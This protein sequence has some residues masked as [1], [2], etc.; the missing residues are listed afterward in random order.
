MLKKF[1]LTSTITRIYCEN[2]V[3][4]FT[5]FWLL[6]F[7][8]HFTLFSRR[9]Y[10]LNLLLYDYFFFFCF[11]FFSFNWFLFLITCLT[12]YFLGFDFLRNFILIF[13][14]WIFFIVFSFFFIFLI[15]FF[16]IIIRAWFLLIVTTL[17]ILILFYSF[18]FFFFLL[19]FNVIFKIEHIIVIL[20]LHFILLKFSFGIFS[21][22]MIFHQSLIAS[23]CQNVESLIISKHIL[24]CLI[25]IKHFVFIPS[26]KKIS[27][28]WLFLSCCLIWLFCVVSR[29]L[30]FVIWRM[31][32]I[33]LSVSSSNIFKN[34]FNFLI[35]SLFVIYTSKLLIFCLR[36]VRY[37][38]AKFFCSLLWLL[39]I[40]FTIHFERWSRIWKNLLGMRCIW[41][42][43]II[44]LMTFIVL[45]VIKFVLT[46]I[47]TEMLTFS[48]RFNSYTRLVHW[49]AVSLLNT[50]RAL[51]IERIIHIIIDVSLLWLTTTW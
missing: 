30:L 15:I 34:F 19:S 23:L 42:F 10:F 25:N 45:V 3:S 9:C 2:S 35:S 44:V 8:T 50:I 31:C 13:V 22:F 7:T 4:R 24:S 39:F 49:R 40:C 36:Q 48:T 1:Q 38:C 28:I 43:N 27:R 16:F 20:L 51:C 5:F 11:L 41:H 21:T 46:I 6:V 18:H 29:W 33:H 17:S 37:V 14:N 26:S 47:S 32:T 12:R